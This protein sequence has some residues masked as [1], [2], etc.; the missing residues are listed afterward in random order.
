MKGCFSNLR[1]FHLCIAFD[2]FSLCIL[3]LF[4]HSLIEIIYER[5]TLNLSKLLSYLLFVPT[6]HLQ[7]AFEYDFD[8]RSVQSNGV[9]VTDE[10]I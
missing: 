10:V 2:S 6:D 1:R 9:L 7:L 8:C 3:C 4:F 5:I